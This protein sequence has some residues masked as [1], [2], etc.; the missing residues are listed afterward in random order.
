MGVFRGFPKTSKDS[1]IYKG[2]YYEKE[3]KNAFGYPC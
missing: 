3:R 2:A 1:R